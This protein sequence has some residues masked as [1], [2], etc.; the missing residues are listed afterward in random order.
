MKSD[1]WSLVTTYMDLEYI[2][3]DV[4]KKQRVIFKYW[5][6]SAEL[7][8]KFTINPDG[9]LSTGD[10]RVEKL[11]VSD[12]GYLTAMGSSLDDH[13]RGMGLGGSTIYEHKLFF[14]KTADGVHPYWIVIY[15]DQ[16]NE[17]MNEEDFVMT[18][19][20]AIGQPY[21]IE[22]QY[23]EADP[24]GGIPYSQDH[25]T[26]NGLLFQ[27]EYTFTGQGTVEVAYDVRRFEPNSSTSTLLKHYLY[28]FTDLEFMRDDVREV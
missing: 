4:T 14:N 22:E 18:M 13:I 9:S 8:S 1:G 20:T 6:P 15:S 11:N 17:V 19:Q 26:M 25:F 10:L 12:W 23:E 5:V 3:N 2:E 24:E 21:V 16:S 27:V 28:L 7:E